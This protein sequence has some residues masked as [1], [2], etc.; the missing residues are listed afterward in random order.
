MIRGKKLESDV[1]NLKNHHC[2]CQVSKTPELAQ[3]DREA[4]SKEMEYLR[5]VEDRRKKSKRNSMDINA[6]NR[7][8]NELARGRFS[9]G[10]TTV[11][12]KSE[13]LPFKQDLFK[14]K[15]SH[16]KSDL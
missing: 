10:N 12:K 1:L 7:S 6:P 4:Y 13:G 3:T 2:A 5:P 8:I 14:K 16:L 9:K 15:R 11:L